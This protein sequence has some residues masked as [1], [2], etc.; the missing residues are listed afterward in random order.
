M[1]NQ[2]HTNKLQILKYLVDTK[3]L[4][5]A[6]QISKSNANQYLIPLANMK[7]IKRHKINNSKCLFSYVDSDVINKAKD[8]LKKYNALNITVDRNL[9]RL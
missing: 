2:S 4:L 6:S 5:T 7:L 1:K 8:Y 9:V 3:E